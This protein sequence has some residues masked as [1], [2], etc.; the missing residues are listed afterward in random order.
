MT[1]SRTDHWRYCMARLDEAAIETELGRVNGWTRDGI[2]IT[3]TFEFPS[4]MAAIAFVDGV[5]EAAENADHHPD[6]D[7]RYSKVRLTISTHSAGGLTMKDFRL[8]AD[9]DSLAD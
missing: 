9:A 2:S 6:I 3:R 4:F 7:I 1:L 5:A 8:A